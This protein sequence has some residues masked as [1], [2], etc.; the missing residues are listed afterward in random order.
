[1]LYIADCSRRHDVH[2]TSDRLHALPVHV[3]ACSSLWTT[4]ILITQYARFATDLLRTGA[5]R[6]GFDGIYLRRTFVVVHFRT[7]VFVVRSHTIS[8]SSART[9]SATTTAYGSDRS[10]QRRTYMDDRPNAVHSYGTSVRTDGFWNFKTLFRV[11]ATRDG[12]W[13]PEADE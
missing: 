11:T 4:L 10:R 6:I 9:R 2:A 8:H 12:F 3:T 1:M 5:R 13:K 7:S